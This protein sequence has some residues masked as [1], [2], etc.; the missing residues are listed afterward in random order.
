MSGTS[1]RS[2]AGLQREYAER[3]A[4]RESARQ[5]PALTL[6]RLWTA[7]NAVHLLLLVNIVINIG[8]VATSHLRLNDLGSFLHSGA[9]YRAGLNPYGY[10]PWLKPLPIS[11]EAL[12]LNPPISVYFFETLTV[13][14]PIVLRTIFL[15][16]S[17]MMFG[18]AVALLL[19]AYP[20]K[21]NVTV[22]LTVFALTG[23]WHMVYY[24]QI[25]APL[26]L[27]IVG[28]WLLIRQGRLAW[29]G[30]LIGFVIAV[31]P[32]YALVPLMLLAAGYAR[33]AVPALLVAAAISLVPL[34]IDGPVIYEQWL[35]MTLGF[36]G[37][38]WTSNASLMAV[39]EHL[40]LPIIGRTLA[41]SV[42]LGILYVQ[43]RYRPA[44]LDALTLSIMAVILFGPVSWAGYTLFLLPFIL[45]RAW[46]RLTLVAI[47][48]LMVP[49]CIMRAIALG[50]DWLNTVLAPLYA[51]GVVLLLA[52]LLL[53]YVPVQLRM[54]ARLRDVLRRPRARRLTPMAT[55]P[56]VC[57]A[58]R[59]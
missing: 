40:G 58:R 38:E 50:G 22:L 3:P 33:I 43:R 57:S 39:G 19:R 24:L 30:V 25:Y 21:R 44:P 2:L 5:Q 53:D 23:L 49:F 1:P 42:M 11:G 7:C 34:I 8:W 45:S 13:F 32:N 29:A 26:L 35:D 15:G 55:Q 28:A 14:D 54:S 37:I 18:V 27:A 48:A 47:A 56:S 59:N 36:G 16:A 31:K 41:V 9:A 46:D 4:H 17:L 6:P 10:Y 51:W 20:E 52:R 12:N